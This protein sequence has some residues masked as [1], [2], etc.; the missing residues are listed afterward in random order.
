M[1]MFVSNLGPHEPQVYKT[2]VGAHMCTHMN[3]W[4]ICKLL[5]YDF[6]TSKALTK[7]TAFFR[8][9]T[10]EF[11]FQK[12]GSFPASLSSIIPN[13]FNITKASV[14]RTSNPFK[15]I[16]QIFPMTK[17]LNSANYWSGTWI[18]KPSMNLVDF[19]NNFRC[20]LNFECIENL[21]KLLQ[22]SSPKNSTCNKRMSQNKGCQKNS[23]WFSK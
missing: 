18:G 17:K 11:S 15:P 4:R 5:W 23:R 10:F 6:L 7:V 16:R 2:K 14:G 12:A 20:E 9:E 8:I 3:N 13:K 21:L 19:N 1:Y 22:I